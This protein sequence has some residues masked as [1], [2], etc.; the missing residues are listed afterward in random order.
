MCVFLRRC[1]HKPLLMPFL[2]DEQP[3]NQIRHRS[4]ADMASH[5]FLATHA[6]ETKSQAHTE[7][8][9]ADSLIRSSQDLETTQMSFKTSTSKQT[10][11]WPCG[12]A[13]TSPRQ[14]HARAARSP[15]ASRGSFAAWRQPDPLNGRLS[16][17][18]AQLSGCRAV[19][20]RQRLFEGL[21]EQWPRACSQA[22]RSGI[23]KEVTPPHTH[24]HTP[25]GSSP[26]QR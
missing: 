15:G 2:R 10:A 14:G 3:S 24:T 20:H 26:L 23:G 8:L 1:C 4:C 18:N 13:L 12:G 5:P 19:G 7:A 9:H 25:K 17:T 22:A 6:R 21:S 11:A 16:A